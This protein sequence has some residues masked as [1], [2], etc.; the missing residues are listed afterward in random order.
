MHKIE[1]SE[2]E[3]ELDDKSVGIVNI[4]ESKYLNLHTE[5]KRNK[6]FNPTL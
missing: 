3:R 2:F 5:N 6:L 4:N 1:S